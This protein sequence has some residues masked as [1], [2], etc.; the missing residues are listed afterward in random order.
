MEKKIAIITGAS[1]G[2]GREFV[3]QLDK[4]TKTIEEVWVIARREEQL[5]ALKDEVKN[6]E[7]RILVLDICKKEDLNVLSEY[8]VVENPS[9]RVLINAAGVGKA[10]RF[11]EITEA[12]AENMVELND[13]A[14]TLVTHMVLPYMAKPGNII[15]IA[16]ASAF[17]PQKEFALYAAS[18]AFVLS[19]ARALHAEVKKQGITVTAVCPGPVDTQFLDISNGGREQ[20]PLKK[21]VTAKPEPVVKRALKDAKAGKEISIYGLPMNVVYVAA[22]LLPHG[23]FLQ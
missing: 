15:Q 17:M 18:K 14:L 4:C 9:V 10:G 13:K 19:F 2:I 7:V 16:S 8:L 6:L 11:E 12:E 1:S 22:K 5:L 3:R 20:K 23:L 21:F